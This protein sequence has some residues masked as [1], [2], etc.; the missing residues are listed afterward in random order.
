MERYSRIAYVTGSTEAASDALGLLLNVVD[1][2][3]SLRE[4]CLRITRTAHEIYRARPTSAM[5][6]NTL[7][8]ILMQVNA[9]I[10]EGSKLPE[11]KD[12]IHGFIK[13]KLREAEEA[14]RQLASAL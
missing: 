13:S 2:A 8:D 12:T 4:L 9:L 10:N 1:S 5:I 6:I 11:I 14:T 3:G 7:R